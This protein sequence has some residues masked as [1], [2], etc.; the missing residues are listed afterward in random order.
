MYC[1]CAGFLREILIHC[2]GISFTDRAAFENFNTWTEG[3]ETS[4]S[5]KLDHDEEDD[6]LRSTVQFTLGASE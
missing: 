2:I 1:R 3:Q 4:D 5:E 6:S